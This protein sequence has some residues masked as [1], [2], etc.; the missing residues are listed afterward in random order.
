MFLGVT[1][2][3]TYE[4]PKGKA[5]FEAAG[6]PLVTLTNYSVLIEFALENKTIDETELALL[7][8]WKRP[9]ELGDRLS[10]TKGEKHLLLSALFSICGTANS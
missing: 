7:K 8:E 5:N 4:L 10:R 3:F 9:R 1:P 6:L 2:I